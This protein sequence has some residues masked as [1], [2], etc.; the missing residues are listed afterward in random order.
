MVQ[1]KVLF[2]WR[3]PTSRSD[4]D[5]DT[6]RGFQ[7]RTKSKI[8]ASGTAPNKSLSAIIIMIL[9]INPSSDKPN[10]IIL[11]WIFYF[12][13]IFF[14]RILTCFS[15][16]TQTEYFITCCKITTSCST[17][18]IQRCCSRWAV[19]VFLK[20]H[21]FLWKQDTLLVKIPFIVC[22]VYVW[23]RL[24]KCFLHIASNLEMAPVNIFL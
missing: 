3:D 21:G 6:F 1:T 13:M 24:Q 2:E 18:C 5:F 12:W 15:T 20:L 8:T 23:W 17:L 9:I 22:W 7:I 16:F 10:S 11:N 4:L 14:E 19:V